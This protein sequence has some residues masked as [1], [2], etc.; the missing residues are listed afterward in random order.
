MP[1]RALRSHMFEVYA[2]FNLAYGTDDPFPGQ[3]V[4][5]ELTDDGCYSRF[6]PFVGLDV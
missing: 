5:D 3:S 1:Y 2:A 6:T 4:I